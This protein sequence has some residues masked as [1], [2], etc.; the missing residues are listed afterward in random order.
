MASRNKSYSS[1]AREGRDRNSMRRS[2]PVMSERQLDAYF[3]AKETIRRIQ[4][5]SSL[6]FPALADRSGRTLGLRNWG[7]RHP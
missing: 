1:T 5:T 6:L 7:S 4:R 2:M 3:S